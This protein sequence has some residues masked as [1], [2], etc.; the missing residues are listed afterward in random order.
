MNTAEAAFDIYGDVVTRDFFPLVYSPVSLATQNPALEPIIS[1]VQKAL[2]DGAIRYLTTLYNEGE[3][4]YR[5]NRLQRKLS[6]EERLYIQNNPIVPYIAQHGNYPVSFFNTHE[7]EWQG[8]AIDVLRKV[9]QLTGLSFQRINVDTS[10]CSIIPLKKLENGEAAFITELIRVPEMEERF[11]WPNTAMLMDNYA[12]L[13]KS[14]FPNIRINEILHLKIGLVKNSA[15]AYVFRS[16]FPEHGG[17]VEF[18]CFDTAFAAMSRGDVDMIMASQNKLLMLTNFR[19]QA[20]YKANF[21]LL[22]LIKMKL[23]YAA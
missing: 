23:F 2:D 9:S 7:K 16:W 5:R 1:I 17:I 12:L 8:I 22:G 14:E 3:Q 18:E 6:E 21:V 13:S 15:Y 19:E 10:K 20:G 11:I 4:E